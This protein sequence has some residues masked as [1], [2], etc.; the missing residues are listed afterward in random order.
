MRCGELVAARHPFPKSESQQQSLKHLC[1]LLGDYTVAF[2]A[3]GFQTLPVQNRYLASIRLNPTALLKGSQN[4]GHACPSHAQH[5]SQKL[6]CYTNL[7]RLDPILRHKK[8]PKV[9][10]AATV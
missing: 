3:T 7:V 2:A 4:I 9:D 1:L 10:Y 6:M 5:E 8:L